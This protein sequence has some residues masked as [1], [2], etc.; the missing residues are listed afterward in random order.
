M[1]YVDLDI[2]IYAYMLHATHATHEPPT[3]YATLY[4]NHSCSAYNV[5]VA[6]KS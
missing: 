6:G 3:T 5:I 4:C 1:K 2:Y